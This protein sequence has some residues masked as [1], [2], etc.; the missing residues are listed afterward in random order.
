M[1]RCRELSAD[2]NASFY[3]AEARSLSRGS[4]SSAPLR[5]RIAYRMLHSCVLLLLASFFGQL[6]FCFSCNDS[7]FRARAPIYGRSS[8]WSDSYSY[9]H[10]GVGRDFLAVTNRTDY[11]ISIYGVSLYEKTGGKLITYFNFDH[12]QFRF[13]HVPY[14]LTASD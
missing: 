1:S 2:S 11:P 8:A 12:D 13:P 4:R 14:I 3:I 10:T 7:V 9:A 6:S 5:R